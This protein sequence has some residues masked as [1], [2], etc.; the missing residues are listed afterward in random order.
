M[1]AKR[2]DYSANAVEAAHS[3]LLELA[4]LWRFLKETPPQAVF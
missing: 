4:R 3:V 2:S 1:V